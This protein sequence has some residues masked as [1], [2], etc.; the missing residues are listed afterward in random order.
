MILN[1]YYTSFSFSSKLRMYSTN[2]VM[3]PPL[4]N[5]PFAPPELPCL[6]WL[7]TPPLPHASI[8]LFPTRRGEV[9]LLSLLVSTSSFSSPPISAYPAVLAG[10]DRGTGHLLHLFCLLS[11]EGSSAE[12]DSLPSLPL[13]S[14]SSSSSD[15]ASEV[16]RALLLPRPRR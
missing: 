11:G 16:S 6:I 4:T 9:P 12:E 8:S 15:T 1:P 14:S 13:A 7:R 3:R 10:E 5:L 2:L